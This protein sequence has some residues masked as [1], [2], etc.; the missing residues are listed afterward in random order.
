MPQP[1]VFE[2]AKEIGFETLALMEKLRKWNIPVK[3]HMT[4]LDEETLKAIRSRLLSESEQAKKAQKKKRVRK[5]TS[6]Q[7]QKKAD[8][9]NAQAVV[10]KKVSNRVIRRKASDLPSA[11]QAYAR[12][13]K[14]KEKKQAKDLFKTQ[15]E[16]VTA[17]GIKAGQPTSDESFDTQITG[18]AIVGEMDLQPLGVKSAKKSAQVFPDDLKAQV[19]KDVLVSPAQEREK[20]PSSNLKSF[21]T[22]KPNIQEPSSLFLGSEFRKR[23]IIFQPKKKNLVLDRSA[24]KTKITTPAA[25]KR[26]IKLHG[27]IT[28]TDFAEQMQIKASQ[29]VTSLMKNGVQANINSVLDY[30]TA[31]LIASEFQYEIENVERSVD[32]L[33]ATASFGDLE[34]EKRSRPPY[35]HSDGA[36]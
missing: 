6:V 30:E 9:Q 5:K 20:K 31:S 10:K 2:F 27:R 3:N 18:K 22:P 16:S 35:C 33:I 25:H 1:R 7:R 8:Q 24:Q 17:Q 12:T 11:K 23:E 14:E 32:D 19:H 13:Q 36:Y 4:E 15:S 21:K 34:A 29:L 26:V 28:V